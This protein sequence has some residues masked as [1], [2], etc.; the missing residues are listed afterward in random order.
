MAIYQNGPGRPGRRLAGPLS[1]MAAALVAGAG[2]TTFN[3]GVAG[4]TA[5]INGETTYMFVANYG[6]SVA[7]YRLPFTGDAPLET[8]AGTKTGL[9]NPNAVAVNTARDLFVT[10]WDSSHPGTNAVLEFAPGANG[11]VSPIATIEGA[12]TGLDDP[13]ALAI[14]SS[15]DIWVFNF[16]GT[17][18]E[19]PPGSKGNVTPIYSINLWGPAY[20]CTQV[21]GQPQS[22]AVDP[23]GDL[24]VDCGTMV[25]EYAPRATNAADPKAVITGPGTGL[26]QGSNPPDYWG[27]VGGFALDG[28]GDVF[29]AN[30]VGPD[31]ASPTV[32]SITEYPPGSNGDVAPETT[33]SG[34][35]TDL[36]GSPGGL[37]WDNGNLY[38]AGWGSQAVYEYAAGATGDTGPIATLSGA[39]T[40]LSSPVALAFVTIR[41]GEYCPGGCEA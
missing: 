31:G 2:L 7:L 33:I 3:P 27:Y 26:E 17:V 23:A 20:P 4:A 9:A 37:G 1:A 13:H 15:G 22:I 36:P 29:V 21:S 30:Q 16:G 8:I 12:N 28:S 35:A 41:S 5:P 10:N 11:N 14:D 32:P 34:P 40:G 19:Y 6:G 38:L 39:A 25:L 24:W 18:T